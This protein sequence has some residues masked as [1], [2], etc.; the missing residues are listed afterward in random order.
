MEDG[1][2]LFKS[3]INQSELKV[4]YVCEGKKRL[5]S[6]TTKQGRPVEV[7]I[8]DSRDEDGKWRFCTTVDNS[9]NGASSEVIFQYLVRIAK[10]KAKLLEETLGLPL[11]NKLS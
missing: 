7:L 2:Y 10:I 8:K 4:G 11:I 9:E 5:F 6:Y 3:R 1:I